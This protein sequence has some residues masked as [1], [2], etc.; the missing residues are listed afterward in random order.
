MSIIR[1]PRP[2]SNFYILDKKISEDRRL[3]WAA[4]GILIFLLGKPDNWKVSIQALI[5]E[6][7][8]SGRPMMETA[9]YAVIHELLGVGYLQRKKH[10]SGHI[11]YFVHEIPVPP[12]PKQQEPNPGNPNQ[13]NPNL[14]NPNLGFEG[15]T[16]TEVKTSTDKKQTTEKNKTRKTPIASDFC[17]SENVKKWAEEK[18]HQNLDVH[19]ENFVSAC[20]ANGY[21][22]LD[23]D[24]AFMRAIRDDWAKLKYQGRGK[25]V[26]Q[27][28]SR[29]SGFDKIDY[30]EGV[31][32]DG[33]IN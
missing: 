4:R 16:S 9:L 31:G 3:S 27:K 14:G 30:T 19:L 10:G 29:H 11:D 21:T 5:N 26:A 8:E 18:G 1:A 17:I 2:E 15:L 13:D 25:P 6:T 12:E 23:W 33:R 32:A 28:Q 22:Y 20:K 24:A 7:S